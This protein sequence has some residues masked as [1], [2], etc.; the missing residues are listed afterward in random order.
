VL[1]VLSG[2]HPEDEADAV[3]VPAVQALRLG[4]LGVAPE[5]DAKAVTAAEKT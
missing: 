3:G 5:G 1:E 4:E 2:V